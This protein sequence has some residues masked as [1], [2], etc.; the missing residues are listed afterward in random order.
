M[1]R[2]FDVLA[3]AIG[4]ISRASII[5]DDADTGKRILLALEK[6]TQINFAALYRAN[7]EL[8]ATY[9]R[10]PHVKFSP[11]ALQEKGRQFYKDRFE[12]IREIRFENELVG[13]LYLHA[14][15]K[16]LEKQIAG[17]VRFIAIIF[18]GVLALS[19]LLSFSFQKLISGPILYLSE[20]IKKISEK[21]D[22]S[23]RAHYAGKD[24]LGTVFSGFNKMISKISLREKNYWSNNPN[25]KIS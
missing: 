2:N 4:S 18:F 9:E 1:A 7:G 19:V 15:L 24:E 5:F 20:T 11:P 13:K 25:L 23:V 3:E 6:E 17:Q 22:L 10:E 8:F 14:H 12:L 21:D 16:E